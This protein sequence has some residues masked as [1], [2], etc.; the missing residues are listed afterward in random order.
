MQDKF[1]TTV[2]DRFEVHKRNITRDLEY[3]EYLD[4]DYQGKLSPDFT[5]QIRAAQAALKR[6]EELIEE[7]PKG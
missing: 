2:S 6:M 1:F 4:S 3:L 5:V 7:L